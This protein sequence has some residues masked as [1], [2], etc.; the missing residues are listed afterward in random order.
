[1]YRSCV[2]SHGPREYPVAIGMLLLRR[3]YRKLNGAYLFEQ[4]G[5]FV[6]ENG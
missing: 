4:T 5:S 6:S 3:F 2:A 1:M